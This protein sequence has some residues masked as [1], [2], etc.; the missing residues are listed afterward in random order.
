M[1]D[2][3][4]SIKRSI[5][6]QLEKLE[7]EERQLNNYYQGRMRVVNDGYYAGIARS[8]AQSEANKAQTRLDQII[9]RK[10]ELLKELNAL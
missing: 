1:N 7:S 8:K 10:L 4:E 9:N 3:K 6:S 2:V 5:E